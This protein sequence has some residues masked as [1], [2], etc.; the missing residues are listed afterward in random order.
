MFVHAVYFW[1]KDDY[2]NDKDAFR[3]GVESLLT[4]PSVS[5][6]Y[7]GTPADT[8]RPVIDRSY[9]FGLIVILEDLDAHDKYQVDPIHL[10]FIDDFKD[11]WADVKIY[12]QD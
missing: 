4:I 8:D 6:G 3:A 9:D 5:N 12:D 11:Y 7:V 2:K 1:L 10:K